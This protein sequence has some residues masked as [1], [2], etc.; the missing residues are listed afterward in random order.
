LH[1]FI[2]DLSPVLVGVMDVIEKKPATKA[3]WALSR[4]S[5]DFVFLEA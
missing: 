5:F 1:S 4:R 3:H 2:D